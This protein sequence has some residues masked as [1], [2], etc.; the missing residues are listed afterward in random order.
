MNERGCGGYGLPMETTYLVCAIV[1]GT[2][3]VLQTLIALFG[4][5]ADVDADLSGHDAPVLEHDADGAFFKLLSLKTVVAFVTFFGLAGRLAQNSGLP[6]LIAL[7]VA[8]AAGLSAFFVVAWLMSTL[9]HLQSR[10]NVDLMNSLGSVGKVY[11]RVPAKGT[12]PGKVTL[13][14]QGRT[15]EA[16]ALTHGDEL[17][18]G[19][20]VEVV[21]VPS[22][23]TV[24]VVAAHRQ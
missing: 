22:S 24:E 10:G 14:V 16:K 4:L 11:L 12:G 23:D 13:T 21:A 20:M 19:S 7:A 5:G 9:A 3:L 6:D 8:I 17:A 15:V 18:T 2:C 1:G